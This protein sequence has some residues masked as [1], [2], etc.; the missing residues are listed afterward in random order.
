MDTGL[1][2]T[3]TKGYARC[4]ID[5][6]NGEVVG[7]V[8]QKNSGVMKDIA[9]A[10]RSAQQSEDGINNLIE[11]GKDNFLEGNTSRADECWSHFMNAVCEDIS[12][13][14]AAV[15]NNKLCRFGVGIR[16]NF[17]HLNSDFFRCF[18]L[19]WTP[20]RLLCND[21]QRED[22][23]PSPDLASWLYSNVPLHKIRYGIM[24]LD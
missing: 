14:Q 19:L 17:C 5:L 16:K 8:G 22:A 7:L 2:R 4:C 18:G 1:G 21:V 6:R 11:K 15:S 13:R 3:S 24:I 9:V 20:Y 10:V 12:Q 23:K